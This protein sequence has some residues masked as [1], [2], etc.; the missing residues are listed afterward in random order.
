MSILLFLQAK[1]I[2]TSFPNKILSIAISKLQVNQQSISVLK[3]SVLKEQFPEK[4]NLLE[5]EP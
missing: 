4:F 5:A 3:F 2:Q 1:E